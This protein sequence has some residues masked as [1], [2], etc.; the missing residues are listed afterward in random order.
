MRKVEILE[1]TPELIIVD[2]DGQI[3]EVKRE[4]FFDWAKDRGF[5]D[6]VSDTVQNGEHVQIEH[7]M[8]EDEY[9]STQS[10]EEDLFIYL[11]VRNAKTAKLGSLVDL[12]ASL[13]KLSTDIKN[14]AV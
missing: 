12:G 14:Q 1:T 4:L 10:I 6:T 2:K 13:K 8:T 7:T 5:L 9:L 3:V 11:T